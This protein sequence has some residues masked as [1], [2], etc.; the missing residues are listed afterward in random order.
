LICLRRD[1]VFAAH[2]CIQYCWALAWCSVPLTPEESERGTRLAK[3]YQRMMW[4]RHK[5]QM[6]DTQEKIRLKWRAIY[7]LPTLE[8]RKEVRTCLL[9]VAAVLALLWSRC[10]RA[11]RCCTG[12]VY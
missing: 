10:G 8:L 6:M 7:A 9:C 3:Q 4:K 2:Y 1:R 11:L 12:V 5:M